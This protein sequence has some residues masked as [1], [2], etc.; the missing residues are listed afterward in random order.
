MRYK[1]KIKK[2]EKTHIYTH[3]PE[4]GVDEKN[5]YKKAA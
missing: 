3:K 1:I 4:K 5:I 2:K